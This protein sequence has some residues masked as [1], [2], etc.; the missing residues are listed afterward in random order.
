MQVTIASRRL[1]ADVEVVG[2]GATS[3]NARL[4]ASSSSITVTAGT[5][6]VRPG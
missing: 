1:R 5:L 3:A 4:L 2:R 6:C